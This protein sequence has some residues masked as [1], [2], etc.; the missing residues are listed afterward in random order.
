MEGRRRRKRRR[1]S[2]PIKSRGP[3]PKKGEGKK[4][5]T[6]GGGG[7][8]EFSIRVWCSNRSLGRPGQQVRFFFA[9]KR[10]PRRAYVSAEDVVYASTVL[11]PS[12]CPPHSSCML[13]R[14]QYPER[15]RVLTFPG[16]GRRSVGLLVGRGGGRGGGGE[17][18]GGGGD[19]F[20]FSFQRGT[21]FNAV[22]LLLPPM[23]F[24]PPSPSEKSY[25]AMPCPK[26]RE[27]RGREGGGERPFPPFPF[28]PHPLL[29]SRF[30]F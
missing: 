20:L 21:F 28:S 14:H 17:R 9:G 16:R 1:R 7:L 4:G 10:D 11:V 2:P 29:P 25:S 8:G 18:K 22:L 3:R 5:T 27:K 26:R 24:L 30:A 19:G 13:H 6:F 23:Q 15:G 12:T